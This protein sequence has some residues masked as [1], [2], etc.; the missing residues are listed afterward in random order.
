MNSKHWKNRFRSIGSTDF[1]AMDAPISQQGVPDGALDVILLY[2]DIS[3][4]R[5][6]LKA[7]SAAL[8]SA[9]PSVLAGG[10]L[11]FRRRA[12]PLR[13]LFA[14]RFRSDVIT[15]ARSS[16][17][18]EILKVQKLLVERLLVLWVDVALGF[19]DDALADELPGKLCGNGVLVFQNAT[20]SETGVRRCALRHVSR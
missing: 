5:A 7:T 18:A 10:C 16:T 17:R 13:C 3:S 20:S 4:P 8:N 11:W 12:C 1:G 15:R 6:L 2:C 19:R 14:L 9:T